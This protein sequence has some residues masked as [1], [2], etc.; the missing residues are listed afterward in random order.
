MAARAVLVTRHGGGCRRHRARLVLVLILIAA[1]H[2]KRL[3]F[4][5]QKQ[6]EKVAEKR[7]VDDALCAR[8][9]AK[10]SRGCR[11]N[12]E[13]MRLLMRRRARGDAGKGLGNRDRPRGA[14]EHRADNAPFTASARAKD[15]PRRRKGPPERGE[16]CR[17]RPCQGEAGD[18]SNAVGG[19]PMPGAERDGARKSLR[20]KRT[21][22]RAG[23]IKV[24]KQLMLRAAPGEPNSRLGVRRGAD[25][26]NR[27]P[28]ALTDRDKRTLRLGVPPRISEE[29]DV[30]G[31][32]GT[33]AVIGRQ[34]R[35]NGFY[36]SN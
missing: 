30:S 32:L 6:C 34:E 11:G 24:R 21:G 19:R 12:R 14:G 5:S 17:R 28:R 8:R 36:W 23:K 18:P 29:V 31:L 35:K 1:K 33:Q 26:Q 22:K 3:C 7:R 2:G 9:Q 25:R 10:R 27:R 15:R 4:Q 13:K 16:D 20:P